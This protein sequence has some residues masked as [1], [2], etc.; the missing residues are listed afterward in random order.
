M[1]VLK[2]HIPED[3][4]LDEK[5]IAIMVAA[6]LYDQGKLSLGQAAEMVG[7]SKRTFSELLSFYNVSIF[8][9]NSSELSTDVDNA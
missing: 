5:Q 9:Y 8:N 1:K 2:L 7:L 3:V 4:D 6:M